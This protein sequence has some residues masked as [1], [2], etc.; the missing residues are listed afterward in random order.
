[1]FFN[2]DKYSR[3]KSILIKN[4]EWMNRQHLMGSKMRINQV[5]IKSKP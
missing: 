4:K 3:K 2:L 1:M 5:L